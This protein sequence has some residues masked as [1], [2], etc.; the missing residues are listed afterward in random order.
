MSTLK[1]HDNLITG[2]IENL[3]D[4][5]DGTPTLPVRLS[6]S[7]EFAASVTLINDEYTYVH[8]KKQQTCPVVIGFDSERFVKYCDKASP[9]YDSSCTDCNDIARELFQAEE[10]WVSRDLIVK[11]MVAL[12]KYYVFTICIEKETVMCNR[13]DKNKTS[14]AYVN[15][16]LKSGCTFHFKL[17]SLETD[18]YLLPNSTLNKWRYKKRWDRPTQ[19]I[20]GCTEHGEQCTPNRSNRIATCLSQ[21]KYI[22]HIPSSAIFSLCNS[23]E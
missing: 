11:A 8:D 3:N 20:S 7:R 13:N 17:A 10:V 22:N 18:K 16:T 1:V 6:L 4:H 2:A 14:C 12:A 9:Y 15:G 5:V 21:G 19:K 23:L